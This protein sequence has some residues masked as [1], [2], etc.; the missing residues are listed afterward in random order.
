MRRYT[1]A[2]KSDDNLS[3]IEYIRGNT[4]ADF[5]ITGVSTE[6][7]EYYL[8][9]GKAV[10][11]FDGL[12]ELPT[13]NFKKQIRNRI[14]N[15]T[16]TYPGNTTIVTSRV[17]GY[18]GPFRFEDSK[19]AHHRLAKLQDEE[20]KQFVHD[21]YDARLE[22][23]HDRKEYL[24]SLLAIL[25]NDQHIAIRDLARNPL[26]LTIM[27]LVHRI[28]AVLPDERHVLYQKCTE[29][30]LNTWHTW[31][32]HEMDRLHRAK[33]DQQ[34]M[35]RMQAIAYWMHH[36]MGGEASG[37]QAV[38]TYDALHTV[39]AR[40]IATETP[41]NP[42]YAPEV[43]ATAFLEFVQD[44]AGLLVEIG[45]R[46][47][48]FVHLT[49][50]E[51]LT[52][53]RIKTLAELNGVRDAWGT[54]IADHCSDP[55]WREVLRLLLAGYAQEAQM[56]L[57]ESILSCAANSAAVAQLLGG[58]LLDGVASALVYK[59]EVIRILLVASANAKEGDGFAQH[60]G[61]SPRL[62]REG[63]WQMGG[64]HGYGVRQL[65]NDAASESAATGL[66]STVLSSGWTSIGRG[67]FAGK[68]PTVKQLFFP[69]RW[70][71][72]EFCGRGCHSRRFRDSLGGSGL[73][74]LSH[75]QA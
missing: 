24:D 48:S 73:R 4:E 10:L 47:F 65:C 36:E 42:Q 45:D 38:V 14:R 54:E 70:P 29:T 43:I 33:V 1:D 60:V 25:R 2:L 3:L 46:Q 40:H 6:F 58:L 69:F 50:Q 11:L 71:T 49:F 9:S 64:I 68:G 23:P 34:N 51:Y 18:Q 53:A 37:Q 5:S 59:D 12:D 63:R 56:F 66:R 61:N 15:L 21:W 57:F 28:D 72:I 22:K 7:F 67:D 35:Q 20:I 27:V 26:L 52:A 32:F 31:K 17:Y 44:R 41:P 55:R 13:P 16:A 19:F 8:E 75:H 74:R 39:L 30:L 62:P